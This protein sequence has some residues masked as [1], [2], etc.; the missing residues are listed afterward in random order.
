MNSEKISDA[1]GAV[2]DK[3]YEEAAAYRRKKH[4]WVKWAGLAACLALAVAAVLPGAAKQ[5]AATPDTPS[6]VMSGVHINEMLPMI[7]DGSKVGYDPSLYDNVTW[8]SAAIVKYYGSDLTPA[9]IPEG[10]VP[11]ES[12]GT[13]SVYIKKDGTVADD[14]VSL[15][16]Y[17]D[18]YADGSP[19]LTDGV[20]AVKGFSVEA[21][22]LG[23]FDDCCV[24]M[25]VGEAAETTD[26]GGVS[27]T[28][29][30]CELDYGPYDPDTHEPAG[31]Y[32]RYT[33]EFTLDGISYRITTDQLA[34]D[35][36]VKIV[37][38]IIYGEVAEIK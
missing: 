26:I 20:A 3:Y 5:P 28:F 30:H 16:F 18:Y 37:S 9:Y 35:E 13:A 11:A 31:Q 34:Q 32:D 6:V 33:A 36:I 17:H 19:K 12:N 24:S 15:G 2:G 38:S 8:D 10:L 27:V 14:L 29:G 25:P 23:K 7:R 4:G 22:R 1:I 21:S